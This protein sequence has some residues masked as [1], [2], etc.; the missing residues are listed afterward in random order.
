VD[1]LSGW[2]KGGLALRCTY[3]LLRL[4]AALRK[5]H[6]CLA[7]PIATSPFSMGRKRG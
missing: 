2:R 7:F 5:S 1:Q 3:A 4:M 6:G